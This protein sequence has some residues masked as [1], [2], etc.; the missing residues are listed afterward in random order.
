MTVG[1]GDHIDSNVKN[2]NSERMPCQ[3]L[4]SL[5]KFANK[6]IYLKFCHINLNGKGYLSIWLILEETDVRYSSKSTDTICMF[7]HYAGKPCEETLLP[8]LWLKY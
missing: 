3:N 6:L 7:I 4:S 8:S 2:L 5:N 1:N